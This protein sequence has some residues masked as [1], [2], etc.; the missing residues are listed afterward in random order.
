MT[1]PKLEVKRLAADP[2]GD[3]LADVYLFLMRKAAERKRAAAALCATNANTGVAS[4]RDNGNGT[5]TITA[6]PD[7]PAS[8]SPIK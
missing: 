6:Q 2:V 5:D 4:E 1:T 8:P 7:K 3:A